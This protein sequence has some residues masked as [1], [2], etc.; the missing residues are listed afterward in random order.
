MK[1]GA[2]DYEVKLYPLPHSVSND[3]LAHVKAFLQKVLPADDAHKIKLKEP[4]LMSVKE[5]KAALRKAGLSHKMVG[6]MEKSEFIQLLEDHRRN[7][8]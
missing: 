6:L 4:K 3:E 8:T 2:K 7:S 5:L 1:G